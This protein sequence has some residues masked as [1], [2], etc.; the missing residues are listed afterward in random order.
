[1]IVKGKALALAA[2]AI[3]LTIILACGGEAS[4][5]PEPVDTN[6]QIAMA[7][8]KRWRGFPHPAHPARPLRK[9]L[10]RYRQL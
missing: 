2:V 5:T 1:M 7:V 4:P 3:L 6:E 9:S 10:P 8:Q